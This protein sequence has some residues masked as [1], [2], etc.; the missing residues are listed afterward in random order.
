MLCTWGARGACA[1]RKSSP[2]SQ[3]VEQVVSVEPRIGTA[4]QI[5]EY[6]D[7]PHPPCY[8]ILPSSLA[9]TSL[10]VVLTE[11][12]THGSAVGAGDTFVAG[13]LYG[14]WCVDWALHRTVQF[15]VDLATTKVQQVGFKA[16]ASKV[17]ALYY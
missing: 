4:F 14:L 6:E 13:T 9:F 8:R 10:V 3:A 11:F 15:A 12:I 7:D 16:L 17:Q 2:H 5:V 1:I